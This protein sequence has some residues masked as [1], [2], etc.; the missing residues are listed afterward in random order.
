MCWCDDFFVEV[1]GCVFVGCIIL[2]CNLLDDSMFGSCCV[3][4]SVLVYE[5]IYVVDC[6]GV[7]W[8]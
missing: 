5:L 1:Y 8:L 4:C 3:C 6:G 7:N 2:C